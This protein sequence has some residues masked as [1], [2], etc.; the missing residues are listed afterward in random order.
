MKEAGERMP[1]ARKAPCIEAGRFTLPDVSAREMQ[2]RVK[3]RLKELGFPAFAGW[4][5]TRS[6]PK[7]AR[8]KN[9]GLGSPK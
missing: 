3:G 4:L 1:T 7:L 9:P 6:I 2:V 5:F 8:W